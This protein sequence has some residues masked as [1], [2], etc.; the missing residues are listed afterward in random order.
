MDFNTAK[1]LHIIFVVSWFA[2]LF[3]IV[4]LFIYHTEA[5]E[6]D[7]E[8]KKVLS[9]QFEIMESK[10]WWIITTPAMVLA[11]AFGSWMLY[12]NSEYY[13]GGHPSARWMHV[14]LA[15]VGVLLFYHFVC[16][17]ILFQMKREEFKWK[18]G[19]L[20][21]WNE[22]ATLVLVAIAF[23]VAMKSTL[24]W[25]Y[26]TVGFFAVAILLM[27]LIKIYKRLRKK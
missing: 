20:R 3:Y 26:G 8:A 15:F 2:G 19:A 22:L 13:F 5:Q 23:L 24:N 4:R 27:I 12:L 11:I 6:R 14:K 21:L 25:V 1:A 10:L 17:R 7:Q 18:S 9:D 16:Q